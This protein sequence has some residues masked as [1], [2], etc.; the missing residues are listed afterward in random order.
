MSFIMIAVNVGFTDTFLK[1]FLGSATIGTIAAIPVAFIAM[2]IANKL[3]ALI[4]SKI[5]RGM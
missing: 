5:E 3:V 2:P 1:A 4:I